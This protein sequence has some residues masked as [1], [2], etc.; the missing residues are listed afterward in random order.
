MESK[1]Q[2]EKFIVSMPNNLATSDP[3]FWHEV[4]ARRGEHPVVPWNE[5]ERALLRDFNAAAGAPKRVL[6]RIDQLGDPQTLVV[7]T[8]Q[9][10]GLF[11]TPLYIVYKAIAAIKWAERLEAILNRPVVPVFWIASDDHDF[12]EIRHVHTLTR[13]GELASWTYELSP[14]PANLHAC[15]IF[16]IPADRPALHAFLSQVEAASAPSD[17]RAE[18]LDHW[19]AIIDAS[20]NL[21]DLFAKLLI[22]LLGDYGLITLPARLAPLRRRGA[23]VLQREI[24]KPGKVSEMIRHEAERLKATGEPPAIHRQGNEANFFLYRE[25][26]RCKVTVEGG[27]FIARSPLSGEPPLPSRPPQANSQERLLAELR[28][29][30]DH[31][32]PNVVTRPLV[33]DSALPTIAMI[34]GPGERRYLAQLREVYNRFDIFTPPVLARPRAMLIEPRIERPLRK[35]NISPE[36]LSAERW[37]IIEEQFLRG[38]GLSDPLR[39]VEDLQSTS[40]DAFAR[41]A[42]NL[43]E[44]AQNP[45]IASALAKT[46]DNCSRA[47]EMLHERVRRELARAQETN[48]NHLDRILTALHPKGQPQERVLGPLAPFLLGH[49]PQFTAWLMKSL[50]L[51]SDGVQLLYLNECP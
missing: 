6:D 32:S 31:F 48:G 12:E 43:G 27:E 39:G 14:A 51:D 22:S 1:P 23:A 3:A 45:A 36:D 38:G 15:S 2:L 47:I 30:P 33:Q 44:F 17:H 50:A 26:V 24:E 20:A 4:C 18:L 37:Q 29:T 41:F 8:G 25:G 10:P 9:Q 34:G 19:R 49:G 46:R 5:N 40:A 13:E 21:E 28:D 16:D 7:V 42:A 35:H 11:L